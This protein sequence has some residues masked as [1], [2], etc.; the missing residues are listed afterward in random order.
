MTA[1]Q[2]PIAEPLRVIH[3]DPAANGANPNTTAPLE[4]LTL[5]ALR[6]RVEAAGPRRWLIRGIWPAGTYGIHAAEQKAQ[7]TWNGDDLAVSVASGTP[8]LNTFP[9][10]DPGP[11]LLF[12]GEGGEAAILWRLDAICESRQVDPVG[13]RIA[14]CPRA[15]KLGNAEHM[16]VFEE[17]L[18][19]FHPRLVV[20]D[21][22]YLA[23]RGAKLGDLY[24]MGELLE[25]PQHLCTAAGAA[26]FVVH[27]YNRQ[28]DVH[29]P[30][31]MSGAGPAEWGRVLIGA[32][33]L[34]RHT[35]AARRTD[36]LAE[37]DI[38]G[39]DIPDRVVRVR[40]QVW[41]DDPDDLDSPLHYAVTVVEAEG[42]GSTAPDAGDLKPAARKLL[43]ALHAVASAADPQP[44]A[45]LVDWIVEKYGHG[46]TRETVSR[47]LGDLADHRLA[48]SVDEPASV[49]NRWPRKLWWATDDNACDP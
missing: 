18:Q 2:E 22:L 1:D 26:L 43:E 47:T 14:V 30:G 10:D 38:V 25:R 24:A 19:T 17:K 41:A 34:T 27:H 12:A 36:V 35:D 3:S 32:R 8:W 9:I 7:K 44:S 33:V 46:L 31:R 28:R 11:V 16:A 49:G 37:L 42:D 5:D 20:L 15:P 29:G 23:A 21:P 48:D 6:A 45:A 4:F 39:G 13:L 40:R